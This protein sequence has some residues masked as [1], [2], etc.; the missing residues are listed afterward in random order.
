VRFRKVGV[1]RVS[2]D[3]SLKNSYKMG[4]GQLPVAL[5]QPPTIGL[6]RAYGTT[7][8][9]VAFTPEVLGGTATTF[10]VTSIPHGITKTGATSPLLVTGLTA[11]TNYSFV[12][13]ANN[14]I[15][16]S[17]NSSASNVAAAQVATSLTGGTISYD[18]LSVYHAFT[19]NGS[20][21]VPSGKTTAVDYLIGAGGGGNGE[22]GLGGGGGAGGIKTG[23]SGSLSNQTIAVTIGASG[24]NGAPSTN[25]IATT[26]G[27]I[28]STTGGG[29]GS[30]AAGSNPNGGSGGGGATFG[31][32]S[33]TGV[34]GEGF[35]GQPGPGSPSGGN[36][37][38]KGG[39]GGGDTGSS[40]FSDY[41]IQTGLGE[42]SGGLRWF[43]AGGHGANNTSPSRGKDAA[44]TAGSRGS[45][46]L[47]LKY[48]KT[49]VG[50]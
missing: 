2:A 32:G 39:V 15:G 28:A 44:N 7:S 27:A 1:K 40:A 45:G 49:N 38:G 25:G 24:V 36:G 48:L 50:I 41:G 19:G 43:G 20:F 9:E 35:A 10:T 23:T 42:L 29:A 47:I 33:G 37:G 12:V 16:S 18:L 13:K 46:V 3:N 26:F 17:A 6:A 8:M 22:S 30:S 21:V 5:P 34:S 4:R 31:T 14:A 11:S